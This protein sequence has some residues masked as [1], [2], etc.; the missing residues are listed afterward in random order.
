M[1]DGLY[2]VYYKARSSLNAIPENGPMSDGTAANDL[3]PMERQSAK[4]RDGTEY[5]CM[6]V[7]AIE[8]SF[9]HYSIQSTSIIN[10]I[11]KLPN[12]I[13]NS[14]LYFLP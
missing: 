1:R 8:P 3:F 14:V 7:Y 9:S 12:K 11:L 2:A 5:A 10:A 13:F 6:S 4:I